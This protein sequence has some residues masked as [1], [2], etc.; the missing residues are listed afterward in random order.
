MFG[1]VNVTIEDGNLGRSGGTETGVGTHVK[2]GISNIESKEPILISSTMSTEKI[3]Q[4]VGDTPLADACMDAIEWGASKIYCIPVGAGTSG[5]VGEIKETKEG[6]G[7]FEVM[8]TPNNNYDIVVEIIDSGEC[9]EGSFRYSTDGG[10]I[11]TDEMTIPVTGEVILSATGLTVK[12]TEAEGGE[13]FK[14]GDRFTFSTTAPAMNNQTVI[15]AIES[16]IN[17]RIDF[18]FIHIVGTT[19]KALWA[20]LCAIANDYLIKYKRPIFFVCEARGKTEEESVE[21]Y[22]E[23]MIEERKGISS[24]Y[25]QVVCSHS[26][27]KAGWQSAGHH[28]AGIV[29]G[30][31]GQAEGITEYRRG[32]EL[33]YF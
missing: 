14:S 7:S 30:L 33:S 27:Y 6:H 23:D 11:F 3:K 28:N 5:E 4:K 31:Y 19:S 10:N 20:S 17:T 2:I 15:Q 24:M 26:R 12:F 13:S 18:E 32:K 1:D 25:L 21:T 16:L 8:G 29:T 9:N 22:V